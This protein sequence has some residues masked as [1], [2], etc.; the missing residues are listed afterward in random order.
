MVLDIKL[1]IKLQLNSKT[2]DGNF[3]T[4]ADGLMKEAEKKLKGTCHRRIRNINNNCNIQVV[5]SRTWRRVRLIES[6]QQVNVTEKQERT[7][8]L[9]RNVHNQAFLCVYKY[10]KGESAAMA[11]IK[12]AEVENQKKEDSD[13]GDC[14][15]EAA[16][17][18]RKINTA[19][20]CTCLTPFSK[21]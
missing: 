19:G 12:A 2:M 13:A 4:K 5:F 3:I 6:M 15:E 18:Y 17:M 8:N 7:T 9:L 10:S 20:L 21:V 14:Y 16:N 1:K 11:F